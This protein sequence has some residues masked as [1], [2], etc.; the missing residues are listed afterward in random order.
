MSYRYITPHH[1]PS[2]YRKD[3]PCIHVPVC[4]CVCTC[5]MD[6]LHLTA[7]SIFF[8]LIILLFLHMLS[9]AGEQG[10]RASFVKSVSMLLTCLTPGSFLQASLH[11]NQSGYVLTPSNPYSAPTL[12]HTSYNLISQLQECGFLFF[13]YLFQAL[14]NDIFIFT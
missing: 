4:T 13:W 10:F 6:D 12:L 7:V 3:A 8:L 9:R 1:S 5:V 11:V 2:G 14:L